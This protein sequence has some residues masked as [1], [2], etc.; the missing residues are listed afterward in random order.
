MITFFRQKSC[1]KCAR[2]FRLIP[3]FILVNSLK[4][5][6]HARNS[7]KNKILYILEEDYQKASKKLTLFFLSNP[8]HFNGQFYQKRGLELMTSH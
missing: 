2:K 1:R 8:V 6:L 4:Q 5:P 7:F 3:L